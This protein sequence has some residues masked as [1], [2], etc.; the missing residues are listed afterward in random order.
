MDVPV[1]PADSGSIVSH[2][3]DD[4]GD[5]TAVAI[6]VVIQRRGIVVGEI[7]AANVIHAAIAVVVDAYVAG[8]LARIRPDVGGQIGVVV[9]D[10]GI[11]HRHHHGTVAGMPIPGRSSVDVG[12]ARTGDAVDGL[13]G[14]AHAPLQIEIGVARH[15]RLVNDVIRFGVFH[16]RLAGIP[17]AHA[18]HIPAGGQAHMFEATESADTLPARSSMYP[19]GTRARPELDQQLAIPISR[20]CSG[21]GIRKCAGDFGH[22][23][24]QQR[25][26]EKERQQMHA[27]RHGELV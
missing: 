18:L 7:P 4:A 17:A 21:S 9:V 19:R 15:G 23:Q 14:V 22:R 1:H 25:Q 8:N 20:P 27:L 5:M 12:A 16:I 6:D 26:T 24:G 3:T 2:R 11:H 10:A 13:P